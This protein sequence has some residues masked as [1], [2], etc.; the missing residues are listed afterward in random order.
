MAHPAHSFAALTQPVASIRQYSGEH[1]A[2]AHDHAQ[3]LYA[4]HGRMELEVAGRAAFVDTACGMVVPAGVEHGF[5]AAPGARLV[6]IDA[7]DSGSTGRTRRFSVPARLRGRPP[8]LEADASAHLAALLDAPRVLSRRELDLQTVSLQVTS[9][10][11]EDWN[12]RRM[13]ALV[14]LS[15]QRFHVRWQELTG[16][17]PQQW[18][19]DLRLD[20]A[21]TALAR[22]ESLENTALRLGYR[23]ASALAFALRRDRNVGARDLRKG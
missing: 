7:P 5:L 11:H 4:L 13:A 14:H 15:P 20:A 22:G 10:L 6:V 21:Q 16:R 23:S 17:T 9:S 1:T 2:H 3:V 8:A 18:L 12:T 19:R